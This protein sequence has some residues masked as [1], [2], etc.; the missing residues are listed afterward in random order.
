MK[1]KHKKRRTDDDSFENLRGHL[2][3][4]DKHIRSLQQRIK[5]LEKQLSFAD[6][7]ISAENE[8]EEVANVKTK[9]VNCPMCSESDTK[10]VSLP[11]RDGVINLLICQKCHHREKI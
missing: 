2:R 7:I 4:K 9:K 3:E 8:P 1:H 11:K 5:Y 6:T 10:I